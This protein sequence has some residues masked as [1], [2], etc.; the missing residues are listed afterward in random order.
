MNPK[1]SAAG[2]ARAAA[3]SPERRSEIARQAAVAR[4]DGTP[5]PEPSLPQPRIRL[6]LSQMADLLRAISVAHSAGLYVG[7]ARSAE[8][9]EAVLVAPGVGD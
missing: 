3:L 9:L 7:V 4:W 6:S 8:S 2:L 1:R 5:R